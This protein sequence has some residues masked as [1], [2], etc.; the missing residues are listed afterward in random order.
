[1]S[2]RHQIE[3]LQ[4][5]NW[6]LRFNYSSPEPNFDRNKVFGRILQ[7]IEVHDQRYLQAIEHV[8]GGRLANIV[9]I[10]YLW[11]IQFRLIMR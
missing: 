4:Q 6:I 8:A 5:R 3:D 1:M 10:I 11:E 7:L 9:V 2:L